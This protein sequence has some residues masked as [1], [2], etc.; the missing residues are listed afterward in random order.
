MFG[1][2][3]DQ[4]AKDAMAGMFA[5]AARARPHERLQIA[6]EIVRYTRALA[7]ATVDACEA[8]EKRLAGDVD[9]ERRRFTSESRPAT[10]P[11]DKDC[12]I[13]RFPNHAGGCTCVD[14]HS[15][16]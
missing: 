11:H 12:P 7:A 4:K 5:R 1:R 2:S 14:R 9:R 10:K 13:A 8:M 3:N 16:S 15:A 6:L